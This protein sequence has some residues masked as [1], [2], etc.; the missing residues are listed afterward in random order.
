[1]DMFIAA[2]HIAGSI[3]TLFALGFANAAWIV[4]AN[5]RD[6]RKL[7]GE[8]SV[9]LGV[10]VDG[11]VDKQPEIIQHFTK[12]Y[13]S[14]LFRNRLSNVCGVLNWVWGGL[15]SLAQLAW[16][17]RVGWVTFNGNLEAAVNAWWVLAIAAVFFVL[18][19]AFS[20]VCKL[21]TG[22]TP[23]EAR[24]GRKAVAQMIEDLAETK[25]RLSIVPPD[26]SEAG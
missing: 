19:V 13:S 21:V 3:L 6:Q 7:P 22:R 18:E 12:R 20:A 8:L 16:L 4:W 9:A 24:R 26:Q 10:P 5:N 14:E 2:G 11:L 23:G 15:G 17:G 25:P 1:M